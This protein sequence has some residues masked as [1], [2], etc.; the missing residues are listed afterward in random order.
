MTNLDDEWGIGDQVDFREDPHVLESWMSSY[1]T[2]V[3][4][5][6]VADLWE[7]DHDRVRLLTLDVG[8]SG[9]H[10]ALVVCRQHQVFLD[11]RHRL[12]AALRAGV[13]SVPVVDRCYCDSEGGGA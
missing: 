10:R 9:V 8:R 13:S 2:G 6:D 3:V 1:G 4:A 11:G 7:T 12:A 5:N